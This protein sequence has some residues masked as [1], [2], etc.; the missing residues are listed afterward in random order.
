[1]KNIEKMLVFLV[2]FAFFGIS[3]N[4]MTITKTNDMSNKFL[5]LNFFEENDAELPVW[6]LGD[7]WIYDAKISVK[8]GSILSF[9]L[10][11]KNLK[12]EVVG[13]LDDVYQL[14]ITVPEGDVTGSGSINTDIITLSGSLI[15]TKMNGFVDIS[16]N[17]LG[18]NGSETRIIG[19]ID[20][21]VD[22]P[23]SLLFKI[24]FYDQNYHY[25]NYTP[26]VFPMNVQDEWMTIFSFI[27][28]LMN[29]NL[30]Q[31]PAYIYTY[32][33]DHRSTCEKWDILYMGNKEYDALKLNQKFGEK[34]NI[35]YAPSMGNI[36]RCEIENLELG[37]SYI[38]NNFRMN[39]ISTTYNVQSNPPNTP[40]KPVG[41]NELSA[42]ETGV[43]E[44]SSTDPDQNKIRYIFDWGDGKTTS[45]DFISSGET[46]DVEKIY[47]SKGNYEIKVKCRDKYGYES[48]WSEPTSITITNNAPAKPNP[49]EGKTHVNVKNLHTYTAVSTDP[50]GHNIRYLFDWGDGR[51]GYSLYVES[52]EVGSASYRWDSQGSYQ[53]KVKAEDPYG[54]ESEWSDPIS[55]SAPRSKIYN[56]E[57]LPFLQKL[58]SIQIFAWILE[59]IQ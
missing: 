1:M 20:K 52:G 42:G 4:A 46:A 29:V 17:S 44:T 36:V 54:E 55:I 47:T 59:K 11:I 5:S 10:N 35:Y 53:I 26:L 49:P 19:F 18:I 57:K 28:A 31:D 48:S 50:D 9:D 30:I 3:V 41:P 6:N 25:T 12:F 32:I 40:T 21:I 7:T 38:I 45:T 37:Y 34:N 8:Q 16:K 14:D 58:L 24:D 22:I 2:V 13:V 43:F 56:F 33:S 23:I 27:D 15:N 39:L 51:T